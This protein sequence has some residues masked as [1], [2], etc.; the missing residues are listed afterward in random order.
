MIQVKRLARIKHAVRNRAAAEAFYMDVLGARKFFDG[1]LE[2]EQRHARLYVISN[3][4]IEAVAS[5]DPDDDIARFLER[6]GERLYSVTLTVEDLNEAESHLNR[7]GVRTE[8]PAQA[9]VAVDRDDFLGVRFELTSDDL[10]GDPRLEEGWSTEHWW[11]EHPVGIRGMWSV[12]TLVRDLEAAQGLYRRALGAEV[13]FTNPGQVASRAASWVGLGTNGVVGLMEPRDNESD[14]TKVVAQQG[15]QGIHALSI[16]TR[17]IP[18][19]TKYFVSKGIGVV[20]QPEYYAMPH[21]KMCFGARLMLGGTP[22]TTSPFHKI[23][24]RY[25]QG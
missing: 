20:G 3:F 4:C 16:Q 23:R 2:S 9:Y 19:S 13:L 24:E 5:Q 10:P 22:E 14:L 21:P 6:L 18:E 1:F 17:G 15:M 8:R 7:S 12:T 11:S 25:I